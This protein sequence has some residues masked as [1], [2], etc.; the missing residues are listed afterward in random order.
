MKKGI[1]LICVLLIAASCSEYQKVL[2]KDD[3]AAKYALGEK[4]YNEGVEEESNGKLKKALKLFEQI[5]PSYR[6]KPQAQKLMFMYANTYYLLGD[7]YISSYQFERFVQLYPSSDKLE[8][9]FFKSAKSYYEES[10]RYTLDQTDTKKAI[11]KLQA[12]INRFPEGENIKQANELLIELRTKLDKKAYEIAKQYH[13]TE[14]YKAAIEA[15]E[16]FILEYPGSPF[17]ERAYYYKFDAAYELAINSIASK[18]Q[19]RLD[20]AEDYYNNYIKYYPEGE[21]A[22]QA[23]TALSDIKSRQTNE[24]ETL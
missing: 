20:A 7:F 15:F 18:T 3:V 11:D 8:E 2:K 13:H 23:N 19:E 16:N 1:L 21:F 12:Y 17:R 4:F 6:G 24:E 5:V 10:P 9:A 22:E 14:D